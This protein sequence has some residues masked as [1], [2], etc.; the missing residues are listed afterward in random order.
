MSYVE[1]GMNHGEWANT[2]RQGIWI[3]QPGVEFAPPNSS[4]V[5]W[6]SLSDL[7][8]GGEN[9][10]CADHRPGSVLVVV[11]NRDEPLPSEQLRHWWS[12]AQTDGL[13]IALHAQGAPDCSHAA[14]FD[15]A[16]ILEAF[17]WAEFCEGFP[18]EPA[19]GARLL[20]RAILRGR[21]AASAFD[22]GQ[23]L[24][25]AIRHMPAGVRIVDPAGRVVAQSHLFNTLQSSLQ[26]DPASIPSPQITNP[27]TNTA[28]TTPHAITPSDAAN[29]RPET[30]ASVPPFSSIKRQLISLPQPP[31]WQ[32]GRR[33]IGMLEW[34]ADHREEAQAVEHLQQQCRQAVESAK[35]KTDF[36]A[37][38]S[39]E[40]R[41]PMTAILGFTELLL[42]PELSLQDRGE[43]LHTVRRNGEHLLRLINDILDISR[44]E[45]G[46]MQLELTGVSPV[47]LVE[48]V[49]SLMMV[50]AREKH[51]SFAVE[52][53]GDLPEA[54]TIDAMRMRQILIN[55]VGNA[56]KFTES[57]G[58]RLI[59]RTVRDSCEPELRFEVMDTGIGIPPE[60]LD[61]MFHAFEQSDRSITR[62]FGGSGLGLAIA[63]SLAELMG[64]CISAESRLGEGS[65]FTV[66]FPACRL[67]APIGSVESAKTPCVTAV[68]TSDTEHDRPLEAMRILVAEDGPDNRRLIGFQLRRAGAEV[69]FVENGRE[70]V[71][72]VLGEPQTQGRDVPAPAEESEQASPAVG[73]PAFDVVLMDMQMPVMDG[74][75]AV[76]LLRVAGCRLPI[77]ALTAN[78]MADDRRRCETAG[79]D[80]FVAKPFTLQSLVGGIQ[81]V[82]GQG[83]HRS[84]SAA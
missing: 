81:Q 53:I 45:A 82:L 57:G 72:R 67:T 56:I 37:N 69:T 28:K 3:A 63:R 4:L 64:G 84:A 16:S 62:R 49:A 48:E 79:C 35:A 78:A 8:G 36:L 33:S 9:A 12:I 80:G 24:G 26:P 58:V 6:R 73:R 22:L 30:V 60:R 17:P 31:L 19:A 41:T 76:G 11:W 29:A 42:D 7:P 43:H 71:D 5:T 68:S 1:S 52:T 75:T 15:D 14:T 13:L 34:L 10:S 39:H 38:M 25:S 32:D 74:Y 51:L 27:L 40:I 50:R 47:S 65:C 54:I 23:I 46:R 21:K 18:Q 20:D 55:L 61:Q 59:V 77:V 44:I 2:M 70:A 66:A 83:P